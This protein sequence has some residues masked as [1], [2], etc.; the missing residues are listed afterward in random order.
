M[1]GKQ[2]QAI[3]P[4]TPYKLVGVMLRCCMAR[5]AV[6]WS[7]LIR[8]KPSSMA[9]VSSSSVLCSL[10]ECFINTLRHQTSIKK[11]SAWE[12]RRQST[13]VAASVTS[14]PVCQQQRR[15]K[16]GR[17]LAC[18]VWFTA[19]ATAA[20]AAEGTLC[21]FRRLLPSQSAWRAN[22]SIQSRRGRQ[23]WS[24]VIK[25]EFQGL[26]HENCLINHCPIH[27]PKAARSVA[28]EM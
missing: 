26:R 14:R 13:L 6:Q 9:V 8:N 25:L 5:R 10:A 18:L 16:E 28:H 7:L 27:L 23:N 11:T 12:S 17:G 2:K 24:E 1:S 21:N 15:R 3:T 20:A 22:T 19:A 4:H